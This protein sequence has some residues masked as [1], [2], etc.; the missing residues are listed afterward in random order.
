MIR[1]S[2]LDCIGYL[3]VNKK[4][5]NIR[6]TNLAHSFDKKKGVLLII[7]MGGDFQRKYFNEFKDWFTHYSYT[8]FEFKN[9]NFI[10]ILE[11]M[12]EHKQVYMYVGWRDKINKM[13]I[14]E[15]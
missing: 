15:L 9:T 14:E 5:Y 2:N 11:K 7:D 13:F 3:K 1:N 10:K 12:A 6:L 4:M 8:L